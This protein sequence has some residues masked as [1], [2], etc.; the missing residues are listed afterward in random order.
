MYEELINRLNSLAELIARNGGDGL[1]VS[2]VEAE[3]VRRIAQE[4]ANA[5][6][7]LS[8]RVPKTPHGDLI[9]R[10][11]LKNKSITI[12]YDEWSDCFDD[13]L[14]FVTNLI[15]EAPTIIQAEEGET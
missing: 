12:D 3:A 2:A 4:A 6:E 13:G 8:K 15:D 9:D 14:L 7:E 1:C 10:D 11:D 5:I